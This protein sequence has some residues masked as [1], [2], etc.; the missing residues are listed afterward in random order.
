M[1][2]EVDP[3]A[4]MRAAASYMRRDGLTGTP[5][6]LDA[7]CILVNDLIEQ[8]DALA[9]ALAEL[10]RALPKGRKS[11]SQV[12]QHRC[13]DGERLAWAILNRESVNPEAYER[14]LAKVP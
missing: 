8:R 14:E 5:A 4:V 11:L 1:T 13:R 3:I 10:T 6:D 7:A 12:A 2:S 9:I